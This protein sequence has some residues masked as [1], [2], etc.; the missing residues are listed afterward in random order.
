MKYSGES[1][2]GG[3]TNELNR[4]P[5]S[6]TDGG[7]Q[8]SVVATSSSIP[9]SMI[10]NLPHPNAQFLLANPWL[11]TSLL[12]SQLYNN[13]QRVHPLLPSTSVLL[14]GGADAGESTDQVIPTPCKF[15][16][17]RRSPSPTTTPK[18][19]SPAS[20]TT[21]KDGTA[22]REVDNNKRSEVW[23]PY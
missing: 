10:S 23:R 6:K 2:L 7:T 4:R 1:S 3:R 5:E 17:H 18:S 21:T 9:S 13:S 20:S 8:T 14:G 19:S 16:T 12:Y 22:V 15:N 11:H